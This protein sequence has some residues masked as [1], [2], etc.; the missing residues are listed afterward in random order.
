MDRFDSCKAVVL[1]LEAPSLKS[2]T[3]PQRWS[4]RTC[5]CCGFGALVY[6]VV[7][8]KWTIGQECCYRQDTED[9][10]STHL[11][12]RYLPPMDGKCHDW[13]ISHSSGGVTQILL[14]TMLRVKYMSAAPEGDGW[15]QDERLGYVVQFGS[16][17]IST[18][19]W[20]DV[21]SDFKHC[22]N[23]NW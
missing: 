13:V 18:M 21:D 3:C 14:G 9:K 4:L 17:A 12:Q 10:N 6:S 22:I 1:G 8:K 19:G 20:P 23:I 15:T 7:R 11:F 5:R 16:L 2:K